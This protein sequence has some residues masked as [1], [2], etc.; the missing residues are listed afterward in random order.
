M[1]FDA[2]KVTADPAVVPVVENDATGAW[3]GMIAIS[4]G[5]LPVETAAAALG[6]SPPLGPMSYCEMSWSRKLTTYTL[7]P[8]GLTAIAVG[9]LPLVTVGVAIGDSAPPAPTVYC[10]IPLVPRSLLITYTLPP[11]GVIATPA[12]NVPATSIG[13]AIEV[14]APSGPTVYCQTPAPRPWTAT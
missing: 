12:G 8:P 13:V 1:D 14:S 10:E 2:S 3:S 4:C 11:S 7:W 6:V 5:S 9:P